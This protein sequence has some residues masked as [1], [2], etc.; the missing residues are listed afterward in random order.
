MGGAPQP[1]GY[2]YPHAAVPPPAY[3]YPQGSYGQQVPYGPP[4]FP[5]QQQSPTGPDW[6]ALADEAASSIKRRRRMWTIG[7]VV[8][9]CL[10]GAGLGV[11]IVNNRDG[12]PQV[13]P[14]AS[15][16]PGGTAGPSGSAV[17][18]NAPTVPGQPNLIADHSGQANLAVSPDAQVSQVQNGYVL[19]LRA[20]PNSYAQSTEPVIDVTKS[21]T[22]SAWVYNEAGGVSRAAVSQGDG[23]SYSFLLGRDDTNG[24]KAWVFKVQTADGG[25]DGTAVQVLSDSANTVNEWAQLTAVYDSEQKTIELFVNGRLAGSA[26]VPG[27]WAGPGPLQIGRTRLHGQWGNFWAGVIGHVRVWN[28]AV[29]VDQIKG[30]GSSITAKPVASWLVG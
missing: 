15:G 16:S 2:G 17:P 22:V 8:V 21:F 7:I 1:D 26:S 24:H 23:V 9:A 12:K 11:V 19:R 20:N 25:A 18:G 4:A 3:G 30:D 28:Q 27:I 6:E 10:L 29:P 13:S 5:A 14:T